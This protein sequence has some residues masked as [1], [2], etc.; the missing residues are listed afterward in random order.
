MERESAQLRYVDWWADPGLNATALRAATRRLRLGRGEGFPGEIWDAARPRWTRSAR[1]RLVRRRAATEALGLRGAI[2]FPIR[3]GD[4]LLGVIEF[5]DSRIAEPDA[6]LQEA[7]EAIRRQ[8][9]L[10]VERRYAEETAAPLRV[11]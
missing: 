10:F 6:A 5:L 11:G 9:G 1:Q 4:E 7:F 8:L 2:G 3:F